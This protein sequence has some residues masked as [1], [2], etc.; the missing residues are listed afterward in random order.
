MVHKLP[1]KT[2]NHYSPELDRILVERPVF[3]TRYGIISIVVL[4]AIG[5]FL[6]QYIRYNDNAKITIQIVSMITENKPGSSHDGCIVI[7]KYFTQNRYLGKIKVNQKII[8]LK[9]RV[10]GIILNLAESSKEHN[11]VITIRTFYPLQSKVLSRL[12][13]YIVL[14]EGSLFDKLFGYILSPYKTL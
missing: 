12:N 1:M 13:G 3:L 11:R 7:A 8:L 6:S 2:Q 9:P 10:H 4:C 5:T 14:K